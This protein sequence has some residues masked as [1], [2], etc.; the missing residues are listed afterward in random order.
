MQNDSSYEEDPEDLPETVAV[1]APKTGLGKQALRKS[2]VAE[3]F[4]DWSRP[5]GLILLGVFGYVEFALEKEI[6][7]LYLIIVGLLLAGDKLTSALRR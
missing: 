6:N 4:D 1:P 3:T 5:I 2:K 7:D